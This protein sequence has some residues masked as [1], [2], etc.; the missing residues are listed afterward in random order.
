MQNHQ[1]VA[2]S[3]GVERREGC[4]GKFVLPEGLFVQLDPGVSIER[5]SRG[6]SDSDDQP[7]VDPLTPQQQQGGHGAVEA[8]GAAGETPRHP[9]NDSDDAPGPL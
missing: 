8:A 9:L 3:F 7:C 6:A 1:S 4:Q 2:Q 5:G